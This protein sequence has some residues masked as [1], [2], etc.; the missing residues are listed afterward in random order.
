MYFSLCGSR[1]KS[2]K[3]VATSKR[4]INLN[5][6]YYCLYRNFYNPFLAWRFVLM[7]EPIFDNDPDDPTNVAQVES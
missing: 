4:K 5:S 1:G 6:E 2:L 3:C 7:L